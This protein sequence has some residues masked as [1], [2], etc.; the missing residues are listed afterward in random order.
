VLRWFKCEYFYS[1]IDRPFSLSNDFKQIL[2]SLDLTHHKLNK[3]EW[4]YI[5]KAIL[6]LQQEKKEQKADGILK[7][8]R[9]SEAF[10]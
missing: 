4:C 7:G 2:A 3:L 10:I 6:E 5:R 9:F 8:R 1:W